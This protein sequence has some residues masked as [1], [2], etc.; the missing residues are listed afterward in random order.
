MPLMRCEIDDRPGWRWGTE[1]K[2][3]P[4][5]P[6]DEES[7]NDAKR[8]ATA[9]A[10]AIGGGKMPEEGRAMDENEIETTE[11]K[12]GAP[13]QAMRHAV[14]SL[15]ETED[16]YIVGGYGI[17]WGDP[18]HRD[19]SPWEN[20]DGSKGEFFTPE[21]AG[22]DDLPVK[23]LTF[24]HDAETGPD[25]EPI[26]EILG[27]TILERDDKWGRW[28][29]A[30]VEKRRKYAQY[31]LDAIKDGLLSTSSETA[32]H[33]REAAEN[34]WLKRWRTAGYTLT[35]RPME[36]RI[37]DV[38]QLKAAYKSLGLEFPEPEQTGGDDAG[39][40]CADAAEIERLRAQNDNEIAIINLK[41]TEV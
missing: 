40:S 17:V 4:Y 38:T 2:C 14:K 11:P 1:G 34:G 16:A 9:Q 13:E 27:T 33:W 18:E 25:G 30:L 31:V 5:T 20:E 37:G 12:D 6:G 36:P 10:L 24:E 19:L 32:N 29:E 21:T 28:Y 23:A 35:V 26:K 41:M 22:L 3:Y 7:E 39:A 15:G 8:K